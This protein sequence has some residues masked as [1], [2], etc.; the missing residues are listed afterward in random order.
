[1]E[2][3]VAKVPLT[4]AEPCI[5]SIGC[6]SDMQK[7]RDLARYLEDSPKLAEI[8]QECRATT[9]I[10]FN[11]PPRDATAG[12]ALKHAICE[13][14]KLF[15]KHEPL[16][17]KFGFTHNPAFRWNNPIYGYKKDRD[18]WSNM[19]ILFLSTEPCGPAMMEASLIDKFSSLLATYIGN[20]T[21]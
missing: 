6:Y 14:Q 18:K 21:P 19:E 20:T 7:A 8:Y 11:L 13:V 17:F 9:C 4:S 2:K 16:I 15:S 3:I 12:K 10:S 5:K 1:M